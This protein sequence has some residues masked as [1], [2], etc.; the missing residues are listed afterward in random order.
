MSEIQNILPRLI[1][2]G[3][4][5]EDF[6]SFSTEELRIGL[7]QMFDNLEA[8]DDVTCM[9]VD[10][11]KDTWRSPYS[12]ENDT[13]LRKDWDGVLK[14]YAEPP[15]PERSYSDK[16]WNNYNVISQGK[17]LNLGELDRDGLINEIKFSWSHIQR[18]SQ[19]AELLSRLT[20]EIN[21]GKWFDARVSPLQDSSAST[22]S[23]RKP[24]A[25]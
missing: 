3:H 14:S 25:P 7:M 4:L 10:F 18:A 23:T 6:S 15:E 12:S 13:K 22:P 2:N 1:D 19:A 21:A 11:V 5:T 16:P 24:R 17:S 20:S 8:F 9:L